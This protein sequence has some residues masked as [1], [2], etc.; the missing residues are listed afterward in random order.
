MAYM[1]GLIG[2]DF[3]WL[4]S[5]LTKQVTLLE[6]GRNMQIIKMQNRMEKRMENEYKDLKPLSE[7]SD[8]D[9]E[10]LRYIDHDKIGG[11]I[12]ADVLNELKRRERLFETMVD[13]EIEQEQ[14]SDNQ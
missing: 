9:L 3:L 6:V 1:W 5:S 13:G 10:E 4:I 8:E 7:L 11:G 12:H 14:L 2:I